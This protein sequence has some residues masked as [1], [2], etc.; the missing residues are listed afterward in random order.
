MANVISHFY[1]MTIFMSEDSNDI[2]SILLHMS[3]SNI[4]NMKLASI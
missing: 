1:G 3:M 2:E 4:T